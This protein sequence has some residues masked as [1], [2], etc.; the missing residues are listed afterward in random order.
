M[1]GLMSRGAILTFSRLSNFAIHLFS[2][3]LL[4]RVLD[5]ASYGQYQEFMIYAALLTTLCTFSLDSSLLYFLSRFP[6]RERQIVSQTSAI[7]LVLS[8]FTI[9]LLLLARPVAVA[10]PDTSTVTREKSLA[11]LTTS[12]SGAGWSTS[13]DGSRRN[14]RA[15]CASV[16]T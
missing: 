10:L 11:S 14:K 3:L 4:V 9:G 1:A 5:V 13:Y 6:E 15:P 2:P 16:A 8:I 12:S 7:T